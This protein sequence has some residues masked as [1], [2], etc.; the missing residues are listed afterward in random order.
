MTFF[1][2]I[3]MCFV[4]CNF[5][6]SMATQIFTIIFLHDIRTVFFPFTNID[7]SFAKQSSTPN[8]RRPGHTAKA[9]IL[10][11]RIAPNG[12][13]PATLRPP[14]RAKPS[15]CEDSRAGAMWLSGASAM[16]A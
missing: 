5:L 12:R 4:H 2:I 10:A 1:S 7:L 13:L 9:H 8:G 15:Y 16:R 6:Q 14:I 11:I 3:L